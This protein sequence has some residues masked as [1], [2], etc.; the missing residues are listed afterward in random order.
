MNNSSIGTKKESSLH[1]TLKF[2]YADGGTTEEEVSGFVAD[3]INQN[4]EIIEVQTGSF[5]PLKKKI[6]AYAAK[7]KVI[8]IHPIIINKYIEV[9]DEDGNRLYRRKSPR[10][11]SEWDLFNNLVYAPELA[12]I[13]GLC[14]ELALVDVVEKRK[15]DGKGSWRRK[16]ISIKDKELCA[17]HGCRTLNY[18]ADYRRFIPFTKNE[19]WTAVQFAKKAG[20]DTGLSK[21]TIYVLRKI[22]L[23]E[24]TGT[25]GRAWLYQASDISSASRLFSAKRSVTARKSSK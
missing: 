2:K 11:G 21:K 7:R 1:R 4:G 19:E 10:K 23:A 5:G 13:P 16:G 8:I 20:I 9:Y 6:A 14:I 15:R 18:P 3:G 22:K 25:K 17:W 24:K 12:L